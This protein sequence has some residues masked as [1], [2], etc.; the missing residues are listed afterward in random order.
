MDI[1]TIV[2]IIAG[3][4]LICFGVVFDPSETSIF[5][6]KNLMNFVDIPSVFIVLGGTISALSLIHIVKKAVRRHTKKLE[7]QKA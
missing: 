1:T 4:I 6:F 5:V 7:R 3:L 2:G